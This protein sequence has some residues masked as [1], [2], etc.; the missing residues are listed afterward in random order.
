[1]G[2]GIDQPPIRQQ[3][4]VC[5]RALSSLRFGDRPADGPMACLEGRA[6][7]VGLDLGGDRWQIKDRAAKHALNVARLA[8]IQGVDWPELDRTI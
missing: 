3:P 8:L 7:V 4:G 5:R 6:R 2:I 1:M